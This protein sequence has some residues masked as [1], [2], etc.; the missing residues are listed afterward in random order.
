[1]ERNKIEKEEESFEGWDLPELKDWSIIG[2][3]EVL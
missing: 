1:V 3:V 2:R